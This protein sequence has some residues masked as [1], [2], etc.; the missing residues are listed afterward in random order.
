MDFPLEFHPPRGRAYFL[1]IGAMLLL[2]GLSGFLL[3][4]A[5]DQQNSGYLAIILLGAVILFAPVPFILY[6]V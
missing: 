1:F 5:L 3:M 2:L 4:F 6:S